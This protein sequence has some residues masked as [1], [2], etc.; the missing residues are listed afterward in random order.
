MGRSFAVRLIQKVFSISAFFLEAYTSFNGK[1]QFRA[2]HQNGPKQP[3]AAVAMVRMDS[4]ASPA[5]PRTAANQMVAVV[6][7]PRTASRRMKNHV[8]PDDAAS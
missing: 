4:P 5:I 3:A 1:V 7:R 8:A 2:A 6:V